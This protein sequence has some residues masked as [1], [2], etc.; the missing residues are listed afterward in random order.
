MLVESKA[1]SRMAILN[2]PANLNAIN[3]NMV[4]CSFCVRNAWRLSFCVRFLFLFTDFEI[5]LRVF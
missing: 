1:S 3:T 2:R 4:C 5:R